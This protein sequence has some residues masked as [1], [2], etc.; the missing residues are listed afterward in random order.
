MAIQTV[1]V[2][3]PRESYMGSQIGSECMITLKTLGT[4]YDCTVF[5]PRGPSSVAI[6]LRNVLIL[7]A[8][9]FH[10]SLCF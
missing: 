1:R 10:K 8:T 3:E 5:Q 9:I 4:V 6:A 2:F 7:L